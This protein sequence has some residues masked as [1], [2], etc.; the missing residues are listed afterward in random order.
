MYA[1]AVLSFRPDMVVIQTMLKPYPVPDAQTK[2]IFTT[3]VPLSSLKEYDYNCPVDE[4]SVI[5][6]STLVT[7]LP[8]GTKIGCINVVKDKPFRFYGGQ[9]IEDE[10]DIGSDSDSDM[11][12]KPLHR[13][14]YEEHLIRYE[15]AVEI[16]FDI[17][18]DK[19]GVRLKT[20][21]NIHL[22]IHE[23]EPYPHFLI[24]SRL[25]YYVQ[26]EYVRSLLDS[27]IVKAA[28]VNDIKRFKHCLSCSNGI[29]VRKGGSIV[30]HCKEPGVKFIIGNG[31]GEKDFEVP[32]WAFK[33]LFNFIRSSKSKFEILKTIL[34]DFVIKHEY[35]ST[36]TAF[37]RIL[38]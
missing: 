17:V 25:H 7:G 6:N 22:G 28:L 5:I 32:M 15:E 36:Y 37:D 16:S 31:K 27:S 38:D 1:F 35:Y 18:H 33:G 10:T 3:I 26:E 2:G 9:R 19:E 24:K 20:I 21:Q 12:I 29:E 30:F 34:P 13:F 11:E 4:V 23:N 8:I 14:H